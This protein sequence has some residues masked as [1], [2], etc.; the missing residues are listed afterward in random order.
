MKECELIQLIKHICSSEQSFQHVYAHQDLRNKTLSTPEY[1]NKIAD[2]I[3]SNNRVTTRQI[4]PPQLAALYHNRQYIPHDIIRF[5]RKNTYLQ[6]AKEFVRQ[7]Y[8]WTTS[9]YDNIQW[10]AYSKNIYT[11]SYHKCK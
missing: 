8:K 6:Q 7:K 2:L 1:L 11:P 3:A 9:T 5:L 10:E 4:H